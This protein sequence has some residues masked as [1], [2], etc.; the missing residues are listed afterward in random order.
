MPANWISW[1]FWIAVAALAFAIVWFGLPWL[2][3]LIFGI[4]WP[5]AIV[6]LLAVVAFLGVLGW[7]G[8]GPRYTRSA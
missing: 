4:T 6:G 8:W 5:T 3:E 7:Y 2:L 1:L